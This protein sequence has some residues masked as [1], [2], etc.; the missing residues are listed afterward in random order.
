MHTLVLIFCC[1]NS[2]KKFRLLLKGF[3][4]SDKS[5]KKKYRKKYSLTPFLMFLKETVSFPGKYKNRRPAFISI[6]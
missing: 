4:F 3:F 6:T 1:E 2:L 5:G